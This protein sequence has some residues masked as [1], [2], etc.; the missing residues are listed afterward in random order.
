MKQIGLILF[1]ACL[2]LPAQEPATLPLSLKKA[3]DLALAPDGNARVALAQEAITSAE[4]RR[5]QALGALLPNLDSSFGYQNFTRNLTAFGV[6]ISLP[7]PGFYFPSVVGPIDVLDFRASAS[8]SIFDLSSLKRYQASKALVTAIKADRDAA[9]S[10]TEGSVARSYVNVLRAEA[11][12]DAARANVDLAQRIRKLAQSQKDAGTGTGLDVVRAEVQVANETKNLLSAQEDRT[13]AV[14]QLLRVIGIRMDGNVELTDRLREEVPAAPAAADA[15]AAARQHRAELT[16][17]SERLRG[18]KLQY[19]SVKYERVPSIGA[20]GDYGTSGLAGEALQP[21]HTFGIT[22]KVPLWDGGR[23]DARR[24]EA[25]SQVRME[26]VRAR[27]TAQQVEFEVRTALATLDTSAAQVQVARE[28]LRLSE[29]ELEQA[30]RRFESGVSSSVEL[31]DA[32][33]RVARAR[34]SKASSVARYNGA[35]VDLDIATGQKPAIAQ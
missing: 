22:V 8:Q 13:T 31:T 32:Q 29:K 34:E 23:R 20:Y 24:A 7:I 25:L 16:A 9:A 4:T 21:T 30:Q 27:D 3:V 17:Q 33:T 19:D 1:S 26:E 12:L 18:A 15:V 11:V 35:R 28:A 10:Q 5:R 6:Q 14:L 2:A